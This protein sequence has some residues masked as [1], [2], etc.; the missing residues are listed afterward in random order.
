MKTEIFICGNQGSGNCANA[1][2]S[3]T[4]PDVPAK[5][6]ITCNS[7]C[8]HVQYIPTAAEAT[9]F[10][11]GLVKCENQAGASKTTAPLFSNKTR[12][13]DGLSLT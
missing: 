7:N 1:I 2:H 9:K 13:S 6:V 12:S 11:P 5:L 3:C 4:G 10:I 8:K